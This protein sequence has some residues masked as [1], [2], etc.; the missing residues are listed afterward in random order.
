MLLMKQLLWDYILSNKFHKLNISK[1]YK[2]LILITLM[3]HKQVYSLNRVLEDDAVLIDTSCTATSKIGNLLKNLRGVPAS[4]IDR[5]FFREYLDRI[6]FLISA[7]GKHGTYTI[8][9][10]TSEIKRFGKIFADYKKK[11]DSKTGLN[12]TFSKKIKV[13]VL[14]GKVFLDEALEGIRKLEEISK[15]SE[16][17]LGYDLTYVL[18]T[19]VIKAVSED[20]K[21]KTD[22]G[23]ITGKSQRDSSYDSD[24]DE[25]ILAAVYYFCLNNQKT[26]LLTRDAS[27]FVGLAKYTLAM[28]VNESYNFRMKLTLYPFTIYRLAGHNGLRVLANSSDLLSRVSELP[29]DKEKTQRIIQANEKLKQRISE[30]GELALSS[31]L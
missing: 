31:R 19:E 16:V 6:N 24:T 23:F 9:E 26:A 21:V 4:E 7:F 29:L 17:Q 25:K 2:K 20:M 5:E 15:K 3:K 11:I 12:R 14:N 22:F 27:D 28:M 1:V 8:P 30:S 10:I 13:K 18:L